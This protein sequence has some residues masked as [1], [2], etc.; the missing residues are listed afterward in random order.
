[1]RRNQVANASAKSAAKS[2]CVLTYSVEYDTL[3]AITSARKAQKRIMIVSTSK[4]LFLFYLFLTLILSMLVSI[5][6]IERLA[7]FSACPISLFLWAPE[8]LKE[9]N[10]DV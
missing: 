9:G 4:N 6:S 8:K 1:M 10:G 7:F 3:D 2:S 5:V